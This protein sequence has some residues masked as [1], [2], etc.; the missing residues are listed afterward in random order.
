MLI[1]WINMILLRI[2]CTNRFV[3]ILNI[4]QMNKTK[5]FNARNNFL[6]VIQ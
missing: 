2:K 5:I 4:N 6:I 1:L 3:K